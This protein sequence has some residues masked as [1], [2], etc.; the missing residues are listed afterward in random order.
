MSGLYSDSQE[1]AEY[2]R[3]VQEKKSRLVAG[4]RPLKE[5]RKQ[6]GSPSRPKLGIEGSRV[7]RM[8]QANPSGTRGTRGQARFG[9]Q[10]SA[11]L[12]SRVSEETSAST[13]T[14]SAQS[15][16]HSPKPAYRP[17][18]TASSSSTAALRVKVPS[19][20]EIGTLHESP[21]SSMASKT[22]TASCMALELQKRSN[23]NERRAQYAEA[24]EPQHQQQAWSIECDQDHMEEE[25]NPEAT[26]RRPGPWEYQSSCNKRPSDMPA[27]KSQQGDAFLML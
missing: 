12:Q 24:A 13:E 10:I 16:V 17:A 27:G 15:P 9:Q 23:A 6:F 7:A 20:M 19:S 21:S 11:I 5:G 18:F 4:T 1:Y 2:V 3:H 14:S 8:R 22:S 26:V 25:A